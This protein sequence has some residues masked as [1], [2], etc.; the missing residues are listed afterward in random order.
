[1]REIKFR[2]WCKRTETM[3]GPEGWFLLQQN[4][5]LFSHG[6]MRPTR[7]EPAEHY[8]LMQYMGLKDRRDVEIYVGDIFKVGRHIYPIT[9]SDFHGYRFMWGEDQLNKSIGIDGEVIG[10]IYENKEILTNAKKETK[11]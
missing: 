3:Q 1:M 6:P 5:D 8:E 4:G 9:I 2:V 10:N 11:D 7:P